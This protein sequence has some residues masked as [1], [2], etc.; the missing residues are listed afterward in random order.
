MKCPTLATNFGCGRTVQS[1][2]MKKTSLKLLCLL[3]ASASFQVARAA[4][5]PTPPIRVA[6]V[7][8]SITA[9]VGTKNAKTESYPS[10]LQSKLGDKYEVRNFGVP[11]RTM[12]KKG[13]PSYWRES[14]FQDAQTFK[15]DIV[16]IMLGTND[17]K[18]PSAEEPKA[19]NNW[20]FKADYVRDYEEMIG[21][22]QKAN[23]KADIFVMQPVPAFPGR[24]GV[25]DETVHTEIGPM[26]AQVAKDT[27][28]HLIDLYTPLQNQKA[29]FPDT[30]HPN[31]AGA[32]LV[33]DTVFK[34][35]TAPQKEEK[36]TRAQKKPK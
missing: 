5:A 15:P 16:I 14:A 4:D 24:W 25:N 18:H 36:T 23:D 12:L 22:F 31:A 19:T 3:A 30:V 21:L 17:S 34:A 10:V 8:D 13:N 7:G 6:C 26:V 29:L 2:R 28:A 1:I 27:G 33:A 11:S 32:K 35:L 9:G 20:R